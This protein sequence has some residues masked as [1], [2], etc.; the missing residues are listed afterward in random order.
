[1][2]KKSKEKI[3]VLKA[4][5]TFAVVALSSAIV[6]QF[7]IIT[8]ADSSTSYDIDW[9]YSSDD[10]TLAPLIE[11]ISILLVLLVLLGILI[12]ILAICYAF[13]RKRRK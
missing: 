13:W 4:K 9:I 12:G 10:G 3:H 7:P 6:S 8:W 5:L 1:M 2:F 11:P